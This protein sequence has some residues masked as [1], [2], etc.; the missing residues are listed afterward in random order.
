MKISASDGGGGGRARSDQPVAQPERGQVGVAE[1]RIESRRGELTELGRTYGAR[2]GQL[3][4]DDDGEGRQHGD[5]P[6]RC[7]RPQP[8]GH[9]M[10]VDAAH[11]DEA[12]ASEGRRCAMTLTMAQALHYS[13]PGLAL[14]TRH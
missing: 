4:A 9:A 13:F 8:V 10:P 12:R 3:P 6:D 2:R 1:D 5:G 14:G 11:H 7:Y